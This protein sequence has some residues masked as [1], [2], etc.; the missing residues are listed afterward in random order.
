MTALGSSCGVALPAVWPRADSQLLFS[1]PDRLPPV[2]FQ[3]VASPHLSRAPD[4]A[5]RLNPDRGNGHL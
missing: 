3:Q 2:A 5:R 1:L 4:P